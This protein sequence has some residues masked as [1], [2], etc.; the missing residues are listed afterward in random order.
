MQVVVL[1]F[2]SYSTGNREAGGGEGRPA[3]RDRDPAEGERQAGV[4]ACCP[5]SRVQAA[6]RRAPPAIRAAV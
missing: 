1:N 4:H 6:H 5:Q 2:T 3:E